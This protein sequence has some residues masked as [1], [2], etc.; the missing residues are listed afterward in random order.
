MFKYSIAFCH[1]YQK[2]NKRVWLGVVVLSHIARNSVYCSVYIVFNTSFP[3]V[4]S[5]TYLLFCSEVVP[6]NI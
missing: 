5:E 3:D 1:Y 6:L 2:Q 4:L